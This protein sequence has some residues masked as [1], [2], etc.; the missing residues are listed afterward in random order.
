MNRPF[1]TK[2]K[3]GAETIAFSMRAAAADQV[4][5]FARRPADRARA[6]AERN[7]RLAKS[8]WASSKP[9]RMPWTE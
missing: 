9:S 2:E 1:S 5:P 3:R 8:W 4:L 6:A 7:P